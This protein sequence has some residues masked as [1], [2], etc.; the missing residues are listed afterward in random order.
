MSIEEIRIKV[1]DT[2][3]LEK[4]FKKNP[5]PELMSELGKRYEEKGELGK[6]VSLYESFS[7][8][9]SGDYF[10]LSFLC[11]ENKSMESAERYAKKALSLSD[12]EEAKSECDSLIE[13]IRKQC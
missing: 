13:L 10:R 5:T 3:G 1:T 2:T 8:K 9:S 11:F 12:S 6:A 7:S 4:E